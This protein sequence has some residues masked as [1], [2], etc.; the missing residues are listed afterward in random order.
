[1]KS[2]DH[3][4][5]LLVKFWTLGRLK[6]KV[7]EILLKLEKGRSLL[8]SGRNLATLLHSIIW[9]VENVSNE[10]G[11]LVKIFKQNVESTYL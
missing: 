2:L 8:C 6:R 9:K 4:E 3:P 1:M 10:L 7:R 5:L 11:D